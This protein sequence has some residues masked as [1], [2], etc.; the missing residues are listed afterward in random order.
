[1]FLNQEIKKIQEAKNRLAICCDLRRQLVH[2]EVHGI[3]SGMFNTGTNL[4]MGLAIIE[5]ILGFLR[6]RKDNRS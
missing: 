6:E 3:W 5:Q 4:T 1:M 2:I